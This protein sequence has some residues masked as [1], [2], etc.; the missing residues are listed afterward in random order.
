MTAVADQPPAEAVADPSVWRAPGLGA[1][2]TASTTA[3]LA[4]EAARVAVVLLIL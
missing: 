2:F 3:R 4:N 1:L